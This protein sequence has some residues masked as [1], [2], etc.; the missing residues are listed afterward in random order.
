MQQQ[1][2]FI[3]TTVRRHAGEAAKALVRAK[4]SYDALTPEGKAEAKAKILEAL[5][6]PLGELGITVSE[7]A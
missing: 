7:S 3:S 4:G 2:V 6:G 1:D 5:S